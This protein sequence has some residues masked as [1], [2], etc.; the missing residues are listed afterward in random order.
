MLEIQSDI[1]SKINIKVY[2]KN[3]LTS[4]LGKR[5]LSGTIDLMS[6]IGFEDFT[7]KKLSEAINSTEATIYRYFENK[8]NLL[9][10]LTMWY[11][12]WLQYKCFLKTIN[13][14]SPQ[15]RLENVITAITEPVTLDNQ[16]DY[17]NEIKLNQI[18]I[19]ESS[20][21]YH[22]K[23]VEKDNKDGFFIAYKELVEAI[24][25]I[26]L[27]IDTKYPFPHMLVST[28]IEG[29][30][31]QRFFAEHLPRLTNIHKEGDSISEFFIQLVKNE[32]KISIS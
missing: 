18:V 29:A 13:I 19:T 28:V 23:K 31:H 10:Y 2:K 5:I 6:E 1:A 3:P 12:S 20:K 17:I 16:F 8:H 30:H 27:E 21:V 7:F 4:A 11:W 26:V 14:E 9:T 22:C 32:L 15:K 25:E 24:A